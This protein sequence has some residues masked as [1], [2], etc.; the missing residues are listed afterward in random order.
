V[1]L[2]LPRYKRHI[3]GLLEGINGQIPNIADYVKY[4]QAY[5]KSVE[6]SKHAL[7]SDLENQA[8]SLHTIIDNYKTELIDKISTA[9]S[10]LM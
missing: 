5:C 7:M 6:E 2:S 8:N 10:P 1:A 3:N 9:S 4:L